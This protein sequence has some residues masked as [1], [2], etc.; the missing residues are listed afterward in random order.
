M[1]SKN[2]HLTCSKIQTWWGKTDV[3]FG[4]SGQKY[5]EYDHTHQLCISKLF[6][7]KAVLS[8]NKYIECHIKASRRSYSVS[9]KL[10][11]DKKLS[12]HLWW[13]PTGLYYSIRIIE[14]NRELEKFRDK[15]VYAVPVSMDLSKAFD[16]VN[17]ELLVAK[18]H[19][20]GVA[21]PSLRLLMS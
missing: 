18:L 3:R 10:F 5:I 20:Y 11:F 15:K 2:S 21:G 1:L 14:L 4:F 9:T 19:V 6:F 17:H 8:T 7:C 13:V 16:T 12:E